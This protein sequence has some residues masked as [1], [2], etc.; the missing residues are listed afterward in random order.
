MLSHTPEAPDNLPLTLL[1]FAQSELPLISSGQ[2]ADMRRLAELV[3]ERI[4]KT[5]AAA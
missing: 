5:P 4:R 2:K 1:R 3:Q